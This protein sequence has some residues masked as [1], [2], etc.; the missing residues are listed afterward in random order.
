MTPQAEKALEAILSSKNYREICP[1]TAKRVF[2]EA[3]KR[4]KGL[5]EADKAARNELHRITG[6]FMTSNE[7]REASGLAGQY[8]LEPEKAVSEALSLHASTRERADCMKAL[9]DKVFEKGMPESIFDYACGLNPL[10]LASIGVKT[11]RGC[12]IQGGCVRI[13]NESAALAGWDLQAECADVLSY[14]VPGSY[15]MALMMKLLPLLEGQRT[16][17]AAKLLE[18]CPA[19]RILATFPTRTLG[20]RN[21]GMEGHYTAFLHDILPH[22]IRIEDEFTQ[23]TEKCF[24]LTKEM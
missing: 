6:A 4:H 20:G 23:G 11:V 7:M 19:K 17:S 2:E 5:K 14:L 3:L 16:G 15:D 22:G 10:Y 21:V 13:L 1:D 8:A 12:D 24:L 9:Y 18:S